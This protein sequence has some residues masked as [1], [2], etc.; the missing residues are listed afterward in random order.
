MV[1]KISVNVP[2][3]ISMLN[4]NVK[5][6]V[7]KGVQRVTALMTDATQKNAPYKTGTLRRSIHAQ[8]ASLGGLT[9]KVIQDTGVAKYGSFV[10]FGTGV[11]GP[12]G[13]P[14]VPVNKKALYWKGAAHPVKSVK[15]MKARPYMQEAF[16]QKKE[17]AKPIIEESIRREV[18]L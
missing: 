4:E 17:E 16:D 15:G 2:P 14:I 13:T 3:G 9:G 18:G 8:V 6:G 7:S 12:K 11:Y 5:I 1:M 10:H